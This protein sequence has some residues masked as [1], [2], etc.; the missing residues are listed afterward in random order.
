MGTIRE[1]NQNCK[2][3]LT[4]IHS[5][6]D[7]RT[8]I[9]PMRTAV[10]EFLSMYRD[11]YPDVRI[12]RKVIEED[13]IMKLEYMKLIRVTYLNGCKRKND[14]KKVQLAVPMNV[15]YT[16]LKDEPRLG[17]MLDYFEDRRLNL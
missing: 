9:G 7:G 4:A 14:R 10:N 12:E 11:W 3:L 15:V 6:V 8:K 13:L 1:L 16:A 5:T 2:M 17:S